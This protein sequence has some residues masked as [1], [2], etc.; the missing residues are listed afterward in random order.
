MVYSA[1]KLLSELMMK[2]RPNL[3]LLIAS[4]LLLV[5]F[6]VPL[7]RITLEA[8]QYPDGI[9]MYIW[10]NKITG[11]SEYTL[12][13]INILN[14]YI[15]MK[16]IEPDSI[17][18]L[19]YFPFVVGFMVIFG[20]LAA[21]SA[22]KYLKLSWVVLLLILSGLGVYD[23]YLWEYDY[24]HNLSPTAPIK[25]PGMVYQPPLFGSKMLLNFNAESYPYWGGIGLMI[26]IILG[27]LAYWRERPVK[28][29]SQV[30]ARVALAMVM[31]LL[32]STACSREPRAIDYGNEACDFCTM[33]IVDSRFGAKAITQK[34]KQYNFDAAECMLNF[35]RSNQG[36]DHYFTYVT[37]Y[38]SPGILLE[39]GSC[40]F[41]IDSDIP[42][43]MGMYLTSYTSE[44]AARNHQQRHGGTV[45]EWDKLLNHFDS[46]A[47]AN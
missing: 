6:V 24:G 1:S 23:F 8:P 42:S 11:D 26:S 46:I 10:I 25:I 20:L 44:S 4:L 34:G 5:L 47:G 40:T 35:I 37:A 2:K 21:F 38:Q 18:E 33:V 9:S 15:G 14:H 7:W 22:S 45:L 19:K 41:L 43:P 39:S 3:Y 17:P 32:L 30:S 36:S 12:Q 27:F 29:E 31:I 13:N 16:N 28:N